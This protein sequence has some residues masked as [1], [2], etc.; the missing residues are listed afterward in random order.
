M[1]NCVVH[2]LGGFGL[3]IVLEQYLDWEILFQPMTGWILIL[4]MVAVHI[5]ALMK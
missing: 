4:V 2:L 3:A 5:R 1:L